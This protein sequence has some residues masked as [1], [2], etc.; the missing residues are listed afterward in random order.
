RRTYENFYDFWPKQTNSP[1]TE[2]LNNMQKYIASTTLKEPLAWQNSTLLKGDVA[3]ALTELKA[4]PGGDLVIMGSGN[5]IQT[6]MKHNL[7]DRYVLLIHPLVLGSG[8]KLFADDGTFATLQL[9]SAKPTP[10]GVIV[11]TYEPA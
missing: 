2:M 5:L 11:A 4:Q 3:K 1:F 9:V 7:I 6:L 10:K 8:H